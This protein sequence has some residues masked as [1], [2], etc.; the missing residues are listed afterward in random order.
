M[1]RPF[2]SFTT[3]AYRK[4][5]PSGQA[6]VTIDGRDFYLGVHASKTSR[7][8]YDRLVGEWLAGGRRLVAGGD[9]A[10]V[11]IIDAFWKHVRDY[12]ASPDGSDG[13]IASYRL[14]LGI[15]KRLYG[16]TDA[17]AFGPMALK[18]VRD[19]MVKAGWCRTYVNSQIGRVR[20]MFKWAVGQEM[21][22]SE[23]WQALC[24]I[25]GLRCG[26]TEARESQPIKP[27]P[28][29]FVSAVFPY[30]APQIKAMIQLQNLTGMRPGEVCIMRGCD[31]D[32]T[33]IIW[34]YRPAK[35]KTQSRGHERVIYL[36]QRCREIIEP[37]LKPDMTAYLFSPRAAEEWHRERRRA[38]RKTPLSCGN[39]AGTNRVANPKRQPRDRY[40]VISYG[41]AIKRACESAFPLPK[42]LAR[43]RIS[44]NRGTRWETIAEWRARLNGE[45]W[46]RVLQWRAEHTWH[47]NQLRHSAATRLR[48]VYGLEAAQVILGHKTLTVTQVY[49]E[50]NVEAAKQVMA[51]VG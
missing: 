35:H 33:A 3:P 22:S 43:E 26:K 50:K 42:E 21:I 46:G 11:E 8:E 5:K 1:S 39:R 48:R 4:H 37:F 45:N 38:A 29:E 13:E 7:A 16:H 41:Q 24:A 14:A 19:A 18:T 40:T 23:T 28:E 10:L 20:R 2:G 34:A 30:V 49:A 36:G 47:P 6:V 12:Y 25:T 27:V 9:L 17:K 51:E 32:S 15:V 44:R 31:L